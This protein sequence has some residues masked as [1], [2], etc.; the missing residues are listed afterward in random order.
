M[1]RNEINIIAGIVLAILAVLAF[2]CQFMMF[3]NAS[4]Q[5]ELI[6]FN[7]VQFILI[8]GFTWF[9]TRAISAG[10]YE[11]SLKRFAVGAYR[12]IID[13]DI[14][15]NRLKGMIANRH[16]ERHACEFCPEL[17]TI[18]AVIDDAKQMTRSSV[19]DWSDIIGEELLTIQSIQELEKER[20]L[21]IGSNIQ[22]K[23]D[24][25][26]KKEQK[27]IEEKLND[28]LKSLP[29]T[30]RMMAEKDKFS[31]LNKKHIIKWLEN[32]HFDEDGLILNALSGGDNYGDVEALQKF[33]VGETLYISIDENGV[34]I[35]T[36]NREGLNVGRVLNKAPIN[37]DMFSL[38][39]FEIYNSKKIAVKVIEFKKIQESKEGPFLRFKIKVVDNVFKGMGTGKTNQ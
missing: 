22:T 3:D 19:L 13:V 18:T 12:R 4:T 14:I 38:C 29:V 37:Y 34:S 5:K 15:L 30:M 26:A 24:G 32:M 1:K 8:I 35:N 9:G 27:R 25:N 28:L 2:V 36:Y 20:E 16:P 31:K 33:S 7:I 39:L 11:Q 10:E 21:S 6:L 17:T 23:T